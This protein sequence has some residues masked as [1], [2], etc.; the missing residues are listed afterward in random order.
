MSIVITADP[1]LSRFPSFIV[2]YI[3]ELAC[4][5]FAVSNG[6]TQV[7]F[8][9]NS[10]VMNNDG[11]A[12]DAANLWTTIMEYAPTQPVSVL[13]WSRGAQLVG[14]ALRLHASDP[15]APPAQNLRFYLIGSPER[16]VA[17]GG[18]RGT[19]LN[20]SPLISTPTNTRYT[21]WDIA[22]KGDWFAD[23]PESNVFTGILIHCDYWNVNINDLKPIKTTVIDTTT[24]YVVP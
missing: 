6:N 22:R 19:Y 24:Y 20:G 1:L 2:P 21:I 11:I 18:R 23:A 4:Q 13:A 7:R 16:A 15:D 17:Q 8:S 14:A 12:N 3:M 10:S 9:D 5:K